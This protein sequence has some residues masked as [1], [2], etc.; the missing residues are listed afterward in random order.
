MPI[1]FLPDLGEG[2]PDAEIVEWKVREGDLVAVDDPLVS[3][4]TAKA[5]VDVPSP[6]TGRVS[7]LYGQVGDVIETGK[8]LAAFEIDSE[9][10]AAPVPAAPAEPAP[11]ALPA[12]SDSGTVVGTMQASDRVQNSQAVEIAGIKA[13]PATRAMARKLGVDL[14]LI[15]PSGPN[16]VVTLEDVKAA[17]AR[18][19]LAKAPSMHAATPAPSARPAEARAPLPT[20]NPPAQAP[21]QTSPAPADIDQPLRGVRRHMARTMQQAHAE[22][23]PTTLMDDADISG[24]L[25]GQDISV[26]LLRAIVAAVRAEPGLNASFNAEQATLRHHSAV[27]I[28]I[29]VDTQ[30]GLFVPVIRD[31]DRADATALRAS[32]ERIRVQ[33]SARSIPAA[34]LSG[35]TITLSNF[36]VYAGKYATPI[37]VP[38]QVAI[39]GAGRVHYA[40]VPVMGA[41]VA[42]RIIPLSLTF[43][44]RACTGGEAARF[45]AALMKDLAR[46]S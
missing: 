37:V 31:V 26:R 43:D 35:A 29:A 24:W 38:P 28:G 6:Y 3:M 46:A 15:S 7:K 33:V 34:E 42:H 44:H 27:H 22:V 17:H 20:Q 9:L 14:S 21:T 30:D 19:P 2:L 8:A 10:V 16:G 13:L 45:L 4:E 32:I 23:V 41:I 12:S 11:V 25:S 36:G 40:A 1:F 5:V 39:L 18:P